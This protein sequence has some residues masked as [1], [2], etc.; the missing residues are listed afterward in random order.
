[1]KSTEVTTLVIFKVKQG[2]IEDFKK[3]A[4]QLISRS[5]RQTGCLLYHFQQSTDYA[6]VFSLFMLWKDVASFNRH[7]ASPHIQEFETKYAKEL[8]LEPYILTH[9]HQ[10]K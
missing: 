2:K 6:N 3:V 5:R 4:A 8:L 9:W 10:V 1:M 7:V